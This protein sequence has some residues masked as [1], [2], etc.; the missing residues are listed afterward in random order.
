MHHEP[1]GAPHS[2]IKLAGSESSIRVPAELNHQGYTTILRTDVLS[3][4]VQSLLIAAS[5]VRATFA[6]RRDFENIYGM[7]CNGTSYS[8]VVLYAA[9]Y[10]Y[11]YE[12]GMGRV[13][14][15]ELGICVCRTGPKGRHQSEYVYSNIHNSF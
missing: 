6:S 7:W 2:P 11:G 10:E 3:F 5:R 9:A 8:G 15:V 14:C 4:D 1:L 13:K 12:Y